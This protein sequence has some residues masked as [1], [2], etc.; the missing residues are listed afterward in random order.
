MY[1]NVKIEQMIEKWNAQWMIVAGRA[2]CTNCME[3]QALKDCENPFAHA[4]TCAVSDLESKHPW[5]V[6]HYILDTARG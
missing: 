4:E 5:V 3:S 2:V 1:F 6:L